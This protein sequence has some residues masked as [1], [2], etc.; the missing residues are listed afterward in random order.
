MI[1]KIDGKYEFLSLQLS[2]D[3]GEYF[4]ILNCRVDGEHIQVRI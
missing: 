4:G 1:P 2:E 3:K